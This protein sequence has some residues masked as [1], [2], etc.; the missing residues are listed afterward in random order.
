MADGRGESQRLAQS[1]T[2]PEHDRRHHVGY[3]LIS[4]GRFQLERLIGYRP[5]LRE[6]VGRFTFEH[7]AAM[8]LGQIVAATAAGL[9]AC[10]CTRARHEGSPAQ[11]WLVALVALLPVSELMIS[12][13]NLLATSAVPP[14]P[15]PKLALRDGIPRS[16]RTIAVVPA[17]IDSIARVRALI[18]DLE[19]RFLAN[20]DDHL[21]FALLV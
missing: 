18:D 13:V 10:C 3:Y 11:L 8:Y 21:H 5:T 1:A 14:R 16:S 6:R 7:P 15:L 19:V 12:I 17:I 4:R 9:A 2:I 20:R